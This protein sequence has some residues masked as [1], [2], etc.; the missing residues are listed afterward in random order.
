MVE[1]KMQRGYALCSMDLTKVISI[2]KNKQKFIWIDIDGTKAINKALC[3]Y[4][5]TEARN[6][7]QRM[8]EHHDG[9]MQESQVVN[10]SRLYSKIF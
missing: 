2:D 3:F 4:D 9:V 6:V 1:D 10:V 8:I 7:Q 5:K